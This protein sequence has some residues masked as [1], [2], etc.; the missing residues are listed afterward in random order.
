MQ[1]CLAIKLLAGRHVTDSMV[2]NY[3]AVYPYT[4]FKFSMGMERTN[5]TYSMVLNSRLITVLY[6]PIPHI[7]FSMGIKRT[8]V[9]YSMVLNSRLI[10][11]LY[12]PIPHIEFS[13]GMECTNG[14]VPKV[15]NFHNL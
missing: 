12:T 1:I 11:V 6:T 13:M 4:H 2:H 5:F 10:T 14:R 7:E 8:N 3:C 15:F 9:T